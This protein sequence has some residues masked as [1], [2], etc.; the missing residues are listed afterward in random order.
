MNVFDVFI[1][2]IIFV[3]NACVTVY[4]IQFYL[5]KIIIFRIMLGMSNFLVMLFNIYNRYLI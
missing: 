4:D 5:N 1:H 3:E 2:H